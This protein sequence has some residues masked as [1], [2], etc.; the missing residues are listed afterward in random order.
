MT[1]HMPNS[2][3]PVN[4]EGLRGIGWTEY[5]VL[6]VTGDAYIDHSSFGI[7]IIARLLESLGLRVAIL[8]QPW[9]QDAQAFKAMGRPKLFCGI[10]SGNMDSIVANY[11]GNARVR[12]KDAY[13]PAGKP[14]FWPRKGTRAAQKA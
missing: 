3:T 9:H 13:S 7:A 14:V 2:M 10:T 11:S 12:D 8:A 1:K 5:D 4:P 6:L